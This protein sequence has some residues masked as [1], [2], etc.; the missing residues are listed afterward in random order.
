MKTLELDLSGYSAAGPGSPVHLLFIRQAAGGQLMAARGPDKGESGIFKT[1]PNGGGLRALLMQ[2]GYVVHEAGEG[3]GIG[4]GTD[5]CH[6][7]RKFREDMEKVLMTKRQDLLHSDGTRNRVVLF[8]SGPGSNWIDGEGI[9]PGSPD[10]KEKT[11]A[12]YKAA[13]RDLLKW[14]RRE[15]DTLFI[16]MTP[17]PLTKPEPARGIVLRL[18]GKADRNP[19]DEVGKRARFFNNW[20]RNVHTGWLQGYPLENVA[21][22]D[23]YDIL[24]GCGSSNWLFYPAGRDGDSLPSAEGNLAVVREFLPFLNRARNRMVQHSISANGTGAYSRQAPG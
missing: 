16:A 23:L 6:W 8:Q 5:V 18:L 11:L 15:P 3:S 9:E 14:F 21:V 1:H 2:S 12:N 13:Y 22:F 4:T 24:T 7:N 19:G 17:A 10:A 20:L